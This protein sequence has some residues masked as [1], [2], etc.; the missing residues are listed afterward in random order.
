MKTLLSS[1]RRGS[2]PKP[3]RDMSGPVVKESPLNKFSMKVKNPSKKSLKAYREGIR[4]E[5]HNVLRSSRG[6][7][8]NSEIPKFPIPNISNVAKST[9]FNKNSLK[10]SFSYSKNEEGLQ[11]IINGLSLSK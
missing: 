8:W 6:S 3:Q 11:K 9:N 10:N 4:Y 1:A 7:N 5:K 2:K